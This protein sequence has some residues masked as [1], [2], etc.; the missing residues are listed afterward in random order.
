MIKLFRRFFSE[1]YVHP[2]VNVLQYVMYRSAY[3][4]AVFLNRVRLSPNQ[5]T[6]ASL[7]FSLL[8]F[9]Q[10]VFGQGWG[11]YCT[12]WGISVLL[13]FTD[14]TVARMSDRVSRSAFRYDHMSDLFKIS[15]LM[16]GVGMRYDDLLIWML[17][18]SAC[19]TFLYRDALN[20]ELGFARER[21]KATTVGELDSKK[22]LRRGR[23]AT[24]TWAI[25]RGWPRKVYKN[26]MSIFFS[27]S[28]H[29]LPLFCL[30]PL[31]F[32]FA[33]AVL[34]YLI[35][36]ELLGIRTRIARLVVIRR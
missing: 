27:F 36:I 28:G 32:N 12:F 24:V 5:I 22:K 23:S 14:G 3:P 6:T 30:F 8:A 26:L 31:G 9:Y 20:R 17:A 10:L 19:F 25:E 33:V 21:Q 15:L 16:L 18:L 4:V 13:D 29:T 11:W 2:G 34:V 1:E 35:L 7:G